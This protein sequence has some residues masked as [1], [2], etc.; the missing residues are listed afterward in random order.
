MKNNIAKLDDLRNQTKTEFLFDFRNADSAKYL[1]QVTIESMLDISNHLIAR[2]QWGVPST[3]KDI[4]QILSN[5]QVIDKK[6]INTYFAMAKFRNRI[7][8]MY[9][10]IDDEVIY[11]I[12]QENLEDIKSFIQKILRIL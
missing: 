2:N 6:H 3:N 12:L 4:F 5:K 1:L 9:M 8:H 10:Q 11:T 7:V